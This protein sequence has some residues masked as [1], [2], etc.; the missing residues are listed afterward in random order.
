M[1]AEAVQA[2]SGEELKAEAAFK[3]TK[4]QRGTGMGPSILQ[5]SIEH[6]RT[7]VD[8]SE[9]VVFRKMSRDAVQAPEA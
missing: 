2:E 7:M 5:D 1:K 4:M 3:E 9:S 8:A 6:I